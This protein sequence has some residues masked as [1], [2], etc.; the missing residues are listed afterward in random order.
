[1]EKSYKTALIALLIVCLTTII[2]LLSV[3]FYYFNGYGEYGRQLENIYKKNLYEL[4]NNVNSVEVD[5]SK[6]VATT[7]FTTQQ[8]L[9]NSIYKSC[10]EIEGNLN[11][12]PISETKTKNVNKLYKS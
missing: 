8:K 10:G 7:S 2:A 5:I 4:V 6:I 9:L 12:L 11:N 3:S 1:M